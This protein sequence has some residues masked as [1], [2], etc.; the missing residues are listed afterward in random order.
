MSDVA[1]AAGVSASTA[2][3]ALNGLAQKYR[4]SETTERLVKES[5][6]RLGFRPSQVARS[7]R[8]Q[9]TG[10]L[11]IVVPDLANPF[12]SAIAR[13]VTVAAELGGFSAI[14]A[15][16]GG[17]VKKERELIDQLQARHVESL[18][19][20]PVGLE[21]DHLAGAM[22]R[23]LPLVAVDRC[24]ANSSLVQVTSDH[25][26][27]AKLAMQLLLENG[28]RRIGVL[29]GLPGTLPTELRRQGVRE[30]LAQAGIPFDPQLVAGDQFSEQAGYHSAR[31]LLTTSP[32]LTAL[33]AMSTPNAFG[34]CR[35]ASELG[36][37]IPQDL[38]L[39]CFDDVAFVEFMKV[40]LTTIAQDVPELG[41]RAAK[42]VTEQM[43]TGN[44]PRKKMHKIPV[45]LMSR[46]SVGK[47]P[48]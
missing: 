8:L 42:L 43:Q 2:S 17:S 10:L 47:V 4:I 13:E 28:H 32:D 27:G 41:R 31:E 33:F 22:Q 24:Q 29:Q 1:K 34:A 39:L 23:G 25:L 26:A 38:S 20:C 45:K 40:P 9:R 16:S 46:A 15:D 7:L 14:L 48:S 5:A 35:A 6:E 3:R 18:V 19:V 21:F 30:T 37:R 12:F 11:G 44:P 36:L